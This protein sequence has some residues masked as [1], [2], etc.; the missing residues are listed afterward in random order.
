MNY[1]VKAFCITFA[2]CGLFASTNAQIN[3][4]SSGIQFRTYE[5]ANN[6]T[7]HYGDLTISGGNQNN[8][9]GWLYCNKVISLGNLSAYGSADITG[10]LNVSGSLNVY[11]QKNFIQPHPTDTTKVI[12]Y[13]CIESGEAL[14]IVRGT[15]KTVNGNVTINIPEH[16]GL[17]T[18]DEAPLTVLLTPEKVPVLLYTVKKTKSQITVNMKNS[19]YE[20]YGDAEFSWQVTGVRDGFENQQVICDID[21]TGTIVEAKTL[22]AKRL[23]MNEKS[24][25]IME[26]MMSANKNRSVKTKR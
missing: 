10:N 20:D 23:V 15:A 5:T 17:V 11:A 9:Y 22:S 1:K 25:K 16:F 21:S 6:T 13:I 7:Y 4:L 18:S 19:D 24:K 14:T 8:N 26:K 12:R 3:L 2:F